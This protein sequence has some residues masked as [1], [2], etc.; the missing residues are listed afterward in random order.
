MHTVPPLLLFAK[1]YKSNLKNQIKNQELLEACWYFPEFS[2]GFFTINC[3]IEGG[4]L[5]WAGGKVVL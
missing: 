2:P 1:Q 4:C 5:L 3:V